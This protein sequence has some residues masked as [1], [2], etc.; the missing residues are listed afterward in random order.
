MPTP[1]RVNAVANDS[2]FAVPPPG[3]AGG[4]RKICMSDHDL[5]AP[6]LQSPGIKVEFHDG[7]KAQ[8]KAAGGGGGGGGAGP[9]PGAG[10]G[11]ADEGR[12]PMLPHPK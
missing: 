3:D 1:T 7:E 5:S 11:A 8:A 4:P 2:E 12:P 10:P 6:S 9:G